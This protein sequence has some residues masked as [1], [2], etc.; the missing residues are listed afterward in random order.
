M[1]F[2]AEVTKSSINIGDSVIMRNRG[3][4]TFPVL[5]SYKEGIMI[6]PRMGFEGG[7]FPGER[8]KKQNCGV[9]VS[10]RR[11]LGVEHDWLDGVRPRVGR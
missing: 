11:C 1:R 3:I 7:V 4:G 9:F 6:I 8:G 10:V 5:G 2:A